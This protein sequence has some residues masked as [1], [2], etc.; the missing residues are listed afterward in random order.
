M[1][2]RPVVAEDKIAIAEV[3]LGP[4]VLGYASGGGRGDGR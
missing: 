4:K 3:P 1:P 2:P